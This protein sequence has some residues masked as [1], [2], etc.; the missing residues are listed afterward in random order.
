MRWD[1]GIRL[2]LTHRQEKKDILRLMDSNA[3]LMNALADSNGL[4]KLNLMIHYAHMPRHYWEIFHQM[5]V[6]GNA[7]SN[8]EIAQYAKIL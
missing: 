6:Y 2:N 5:Y 3:L 7:Y 8:D 4:G 1:F